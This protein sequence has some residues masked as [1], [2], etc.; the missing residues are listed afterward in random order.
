MQKSRLIS[1]LNLI[2]PLFFLTINLYA[3][4]DHPL[5]HY[6]ILIKPVFVE[7]KVRI[8]NLPKNR[9]Q[10]F[11]YNPDSITNIRV[12]DQ[13]HLDIKVSKDTQN[14][15]C[16]HN[17]KGDIFVSF[18]SEIKEYIDDL[19]NTKKLSNVSLEKT[20]II[21]GSNLS[22]VPLF[23]EEKG[24][25]PSISLTLS[26]KDLNS[27]MSSLGNKMDYNNLKSPKDLYSS[28]FVAG[29]I[30]NRS[31]KINGTKYSYSFIGT[32]NKKVSA[33]LQNL[34]KTIAV[35]QYDL[36]GYSPIK[37]MNIL[38]IKSKDIKRGHGFQYNNVIV[39]M[40]PEIFDFKDI[41]LLK[42]LA[43]EHYHLW[44][45]NY[46]K[47]SPVL[48]KELL[49]FQE[50]VTNYYALITL[51]SA[52]IINEKVFLKHISDK[53]IKDDSSYKNSDLFIAMALDIEIMKASNLKLNLDNL[54]KGLALKKEIL[55][56][57]YDNQKIKQEIINLVNWDV[58]S[59]FDKYIN[60]KNKISVDQYFE[61]LGLRFSK[62]L[63]LV[64]FR[65]TRPYKKWLSR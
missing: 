51:V 46:I 55:S 34:Y 12:K 45:G 63:N 42:L 53:Y 16:V 26:T 29:I 65:E 61:Y 52:R 59:F 7:V 6:D 43:H 56:I 2:F 36:W 10:C 27:F 40:L 23:K 17:V 41:E 35:K 30:K 9:L 62:N 57:G 47:P 32:W 13:K 58:S 20:V 39:Y 28:L 5:I 49:W 50:G 24:I 60:Q 48:E 54:M 33:Q 11:E 15:F 37:K 3:F 64:K 38:F 44:N 1:K 21:H 8:S 22:I 19:G 18:N 31:V 14:T 25:E 4:K